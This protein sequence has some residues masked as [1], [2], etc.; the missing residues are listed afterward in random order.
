MST[1]N[2]NFSAGPATLPLPVLEQAKE[3]FLSYPGAGASIMEISHRS[4]VFLKVLEEAK[5][6]IKELLGMSDDYCILFTP[7][8]ATMQFS[9]L[10]MNFLNGKTADYLHV[11]SWA[12][13]AI[14]SASR[15][16]T[17]RKAWSG[18][19]ENFV[20]LPKDSEL[21][22]DPNAAY[23]HFTSNETIQ[24]IQFL[25]EPDVKGKDLFCDA[26]SD[27]LCRPTDISKYAL[28]YA[29]AQKNIGPSGTAVVI[30]RKGL[31]DRV[32]EN[33]PPL[34]DYKVLADND[35]LYNT[36]STFTIYMI[37]LVSRWLLQTVGG[38]DKMFALNQ[39]KAAL[40][41]DT[42]DKSQGYYKGHAVPENRSIMN[43]AFRLGSEELEKKF[44]AEAT[45]AGLDGLKGH[46]SVG[47]C[48]ASIYNAMP[49]E[50][51][52]ALVDFMLEFQRTNG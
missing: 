10:A 16:G 14:E 52:Q 43:V 35:S 30:L 31:L 9:M 11:G 21:D 2:Y 40:L 13:K 37:G 33:L 45:A 22:L 27:F 25:Q 38:L 3:E 41:Y 19:A 4:K 36:P 42:I 6:N 44:L 29:G 1:R 39:E 26:S 18:K 49:A 50:G 23:V 34:L 8:G 46:R 20:R 15:F 17:V 51:V 47:G 48:R 12:S 7:G 32:P 24:G 5:N 28:L